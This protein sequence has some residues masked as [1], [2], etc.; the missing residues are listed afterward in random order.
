MQTCRTLAGTFKG[1][2]VSALPTIVFYIFLFLVVFFV[3][4]SQFAMVLTG[5]TTLFQLRHRQRNDNRTYIIMFFIPLVLCILAFLAS[6][7]AVLCALLNFGVPFFL[8]IWRSSQFDPK[9]HLGFAMTFVFLELRPP[10]PE[11]LG[12]ALLAVAF[13]QGALLAALALSARRWRPADP[14]LQ[15]PAGLHR[16]S[17]LMEQMAREGPSQAVDRELYDTAQR[18]H[19]L[20][21]ARRRLLRTPDPQRGR[22]HFLAL[23]YQRT[24]YLVSDESWKESAA[25]PVFSHA[26]HALSQA[27]DACERARTPEERAALLAR[28]MEQLEHPAVPEGR[29]R[30]FYRN[31]LHTV[32]LFCQEP[33]QVP[34][35]L[36]WRR[37]PWRAVL[38]DF[39]QRCSV[40]RFEFRFALQ[41]GL[42]MAVSTTVSL[43][44][45]YEHAYWFPL[46]SFLLLQP[47]YEDSAHRMVTRPIGTAIGCV[48]V[49]LAYP[50]LGGMVG[51]FLFSLVMISLMYCCT[52]G[53][54][55]QPIFSTAFALTMATLTLE[56]SEAIQ[57]RLLYLAMAVA[58]VLVVNHFFFPNRKEQQFRSNLRE[59]TRL[60]GVYW[61]LIRRSLREPFDTAVFCELLAQFHMVHHAVA[62]YVAGLP[63]SEA[64]DYRRMLL[65]FWSMFSQLEQIGCLV[66][67]ELVREEDYG[68]L[69]HLAERIARAIS[70]L[71][72]GL[73]DIRPDGVAQ[74]DLG[75]LLERYL[76]N[77][78]ALL[79][80]ASSLPVRPRGG[81]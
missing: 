30:I 26:L 29:L 2:L 64:A 21:Y 53:T 32:C 46:H 12:R 75:H 20:G 76:A 15:V 36:A 39:R 80:L 18:L 57:L 52:P 45:G 67:S 60:Q 62:C 70:P 13:C 78:R 72:P 33:E 43:L 38:L 59:L 3:F 54:W 6:R 55:V 31:V 34:V 7:T 42:V 69:D 22:Y 19:Q 17:E 65:V 73:G 14:G 63:A 79:A 61:G 11:E 4:G 28:L 40:D 74:A 47:S 77:G 23:L 58:L 37:V 27:V 81:L 35:G 66:Q 48:V 50:H 9:G 10:A 56:E 44:W 49:H 41:L 5:T 68:P 1:R 24:A 16:L 8:V 71:Q 25:L 51:V